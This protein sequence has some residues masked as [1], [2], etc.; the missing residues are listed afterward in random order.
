[1]HDDPLKF[2]SLARQADPDY[3]QTL[4][5]PTETFAVT[6]RCVSPA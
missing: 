4:T 6:P 3:P 2:Y 5:Y 1:M